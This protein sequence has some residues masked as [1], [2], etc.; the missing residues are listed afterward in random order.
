VREDLESPTAFL[1]ARLGERSAAD[2]LRGYEAWWRDEGAAISATVD[3]AGTPWLRLFDALGGRCDEVLFP[4]G[5]RALLQRGYREGVVAA[6]FEGRSL[7]LPY[8]LGY[9]TSFYDPGLYCPYT[10]SLA[11]AVPLEKYAAPAVRDRFLPRLL[12][13]DGTAWQGATWMTE[14]RGGS[15]LGATVETVARRDGDRWRL[16][17]DKHF[18]SNVGAELAVVAAR[19]EDAPSGVRGLGLFLVPHR[20]EDGTLNYLI[21]RLKDKIATRS[22]PTGEVELRDSEA[23]PLGGPGSGIYLILE[24]LNLSRVANSVASAALAQR[25]LADAWAFAD[26]RVAFGKPVAQHPLLRHQLTEHH[27]EVECAFALAWE[28]VRL[29]D[30]VWRE[31]PPYSERHHLFR[32]I[33]HLAKYWTAEVAVQ[34][35]KWAIEVHGGAGTLAET[36]VERWLREAMILAIWEGTPHRQMLDG[37]DVMQHKKAHRLLLRRLAE[38]ADPARLADVT[39]R[40][41]T[42][43]ALPEETREAEVEGVFRTLAR[44]TGDTLT[45]TPGPAGG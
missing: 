19:P 16:S 39:S 8:L 44:F 6:A 40:V 23:Y 11:T 9:V 1:A 13:R 26:A 10:V 27:R 2:R 32:L 34:T 43:L 21:R 20:R 41:E 28:A 42:F 15:D 4:A 38:R 37:L 3:R 29:L 35:A 7:R 31:T 17:G 25:A 36:G 18:A 30:E 45:L 22:V 33:A 5:Y 12:R 24:V 14:A